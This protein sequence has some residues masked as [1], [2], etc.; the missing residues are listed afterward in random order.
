VYW[1]AGACA[2]LAVASAALGPAVRARVAA[3]ATAH[4]LDVR[5]GA[6]RPGWFAIRLLDVTLSARGGGVLAVIREVRIGVTAG[7]RPSDIELRGGSVDLE[8]PLDAIRRQ[9]EPSGAV[10]RAST[11]P[12]TPIHGHDLAVAWHDGPRA[13]EW[14]GV[15]FARDSRGTHFA[16]D[17]GTLHRDAARLT[18]EALACEI[19]PDHELRH[20]HARAATVGWD[21]PVRLSDDDGGPDESSAS[22]VANPPLEPLPRLPDPRALRVRVAT[23]AQLATPR[24]PVGAE[25]LVDDFTW[26]VGAG[27]PRVALTLGPGP[28]SVRRTPSH[29][30][31]QYS[32]RAGGDGTSLTMR[33]LLPTDAGD[34]SLTLEGGPVS[35]AVLGVHEGAMGLFDVDRA[36]VGGRAT[37]RLAGDGSTLTFDLE[38]TARNLSLHQPGLAAEPVRRMDVQLTARGTLDDTGTLRFDDFGATF[39]LLHLAGSGVLE[40]HPDHVVASFRFE[41]PSATCQSL[42]DS[43]PTALLPALQGARW[44]G[45]FGARGTFALD[46]RDP[47]AMELAYD[48]Q[49]QCRAVDVPPELAR[50]RFKQPFQQRI[51]LPDGSTAE[52]ASGPGSANWTS[53]GSISPYMQLAVMTTEDGAFPYHHG[54]NVAAIKASI[55]TNIK[56]H[57][58]VR[59]ASTITMQLAKNL[60]LTRQKTLSRKL[61]EVVLTDYLEQVFSK[62]ELME[63]YLNVVEFGPA[64][65]GI[66]AASEYYFGRTPAE[67]NV[68][69]SLFLSSLLPSPRRYGGMRDLDEAPEG[70]MRGLRNLM[71]I[72]KKRH[73][74]SDAELDEGLAEKVVFWHGGVRP[75][76]RP[77]AI[78]RSSLDGTDSS[79]AD[80]PIDAP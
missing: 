16:A 40:Q 6:V 15:S 65:Y 58:F 3:S 8:G 54:F 30:D 14:Q 66:T 22:V 71:R 25:I 5:I 49:D 48:V 74:L 13:S 70:W 57:R 69:E 20:L 17:R 24:L 78:R 76:P 1:G 35:L 38:D 26:Q 59:G 23:L 46:T 9:M 75:P 28:L 80:T 45:T 73:L 42:L 33:A 37:V 67:L 41:L 4:N 11:V 53:L 47:D 10:E 77:P 29:L 55:I 63:L 50:S 44:A 36:T 19:G 39:G 61:E 32:S 34:G 27:D 7:F 52:Q 72:A 64:V 60:F 51:Y 43:I 79:E 62:D 56:A 12:G 68:A 21:G 18:L 31:L 2:A